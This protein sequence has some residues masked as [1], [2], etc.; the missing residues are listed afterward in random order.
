MGKEGYKGERRIYAISEKELGANGKESEDRWVQRLTMKN[1]ASTTQM[2]ARIGWC[3][4]HPSCVAPSR[5]QSANS[6]AIRSL[7]YSNPYN[8]ERKEEGVS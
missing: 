6:C 3:R 2:N 1:H 4:R 8:G 7:S 5:P